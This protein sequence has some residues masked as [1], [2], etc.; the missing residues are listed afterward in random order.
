MIYFDAAATSMPKPPSVYTRALVAM[1]TFASPGRGG[2]RAAMRAAEAVYACR[3]AA[4]AL[5]DAAPERV[6]FTMNA[7][8]GL[9]IAI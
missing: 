4:G 2:H 7:T 8:H 6:V 9:N 5:F 3:E 1:R